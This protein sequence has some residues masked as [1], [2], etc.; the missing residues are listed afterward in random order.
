MARQKETVDKARAGLENGIPVRRQTF[1]DSER[2][3]LGNYQLLTDK[4]VIAVFNTDEGAD[5]IR[6]ADLDLDA[7]LTA[8]VG[9]VSISARIESGVGHDGR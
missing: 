4:N 6:I 1:T 3:I 9:E 7:D 2:A 8:G 5:D